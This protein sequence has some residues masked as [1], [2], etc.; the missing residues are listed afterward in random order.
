MPRVP[1][2]FLQLADGT[3]YRALEAYP[4]AGPLTDSGYSAPAVDDVLRAPTADF[5]ARQVRLLAPRGRAW[6][7]DE[8]AAPWRSKTQHSVWLLIGHGLAE[9]YTSITA[10]LDAAFPGKAGEAALGD[11][12][13]QHGLPDA[14][15]AS[16]DS[17][18]ARRRAVQAA[19]LAQGGL[20]R[21]DAL[22]LLMQAGAP[23]AV[24][25]EQRGFECG[26]DE[27]GLD[28]LGSANCTHEIYVSGVTTERWLDCGNETLDQPLGTLEINAAT[29]ALERA[30]H[31]HTMII[32]EFGELA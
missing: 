8:A 23:D 2:I 27:C 31:S 28:D 13:F 18:L 29:C 9:L 32:Y 22:R 25:T 4:P 19:R 10:A 6:N 7:S 15:A 11:W 16:D 17:L 3:R 21:I 26:W 14:C 30:R 5:L 20:S 1:L 24:V 12:E